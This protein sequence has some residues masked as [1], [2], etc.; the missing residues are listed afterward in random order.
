MVD[1][2]PQAIKAIEA[3]E[4]NSFT[5]AEQLQLLEQLANLANDSAQQAA[6]M[7]NQVLSQIA[8]ELIPVAYVPQSDGFLQGVSI[9]ISNDGDLSQVCYC[10]DS[11]QFLAGV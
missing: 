4:D 6:M 8:V 11:P 3:L 10:N 1:D 9:N 7:A 2:N 5:F